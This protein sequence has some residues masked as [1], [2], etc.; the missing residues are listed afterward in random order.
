V[1]HFGQVSSIFFDTGEFTST[2][3]FDPSREF[4]E[5][6]LG[7]ETQKKDRTNKKAARRPLVLFYP[8]PKRF[9]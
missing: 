2:N 4:T 7:F 6:V 3:F 5:L 1:F 8:M 9:A